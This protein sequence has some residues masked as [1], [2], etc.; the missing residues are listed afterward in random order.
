MFGQPQT[1]VGP[2]DAIQLMRDS[3][4][5]LDVT[6]RNLNEIYVVAIRLYNMGLL[7]TTLRGAVHQLRDQVFAEEA[8]FQRLVVRTIESNPALVAARIA[9][10]PA[11]TFVPRPTKRPDLPPA[12]VG[13]PPAVPAPVPT[14]GMT[15]TLPDG[16]S[17]TYVAALIVV[18]ALIAAAAVVA[19]V[20]VQELG[21]IARNAQRL[22][23]NS[24]T[25]LAQLQATEA[26]Y[27]D[28]LQRGGS[29]V[30]CAGLF[31]VPD[32]PQESFEGG[33]F[34]W[35]PAIGGVAVLVAIGWAAKRYGG[36]MEE[37]T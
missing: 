35:I 18:I 8:R 12:N 3:A 30:Q 31:A 4:L 32:A 27:I 22:N 25:F 24:Q 28:C 2:F 13:K 36:E 10:I 34:P 19:V 26:R 7:T 20:G 15:V 9:G 11:A 5:Q 17:G 23:F 21:A 1:K 14:Q 37:Q 6:E 16:R 29:L 33:G